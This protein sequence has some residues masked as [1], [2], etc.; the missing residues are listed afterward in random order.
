MHCSFCNVNY[1]IIGR[2]ENFDNDFQYIAV[3]S[4]ITSLLPNNQTLYHMHPSGTK[5]PSL[6]AEIMDKESKKK[7][8]IDYFSQL[9]EFQIRSLYEMYKVDF[10]LF[11][12][13]A[14]PYVKAEQN[15]L[16]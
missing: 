10:E 4:N 6:A 8:V 15:K 1:T 2:V 9:N 7:K 3:K 14:Y 5:D 16:Q 12:Y 11:G 13:T